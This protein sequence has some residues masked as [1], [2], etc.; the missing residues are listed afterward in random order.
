MALGFRGLSHPGCWF[1]SGQDCFLSKTER[2]LGLHTPR[3]P[4]C[5]R[6]PSDVG[7]YPR[8]LTSPS[9]ASTP[10]KFPGPGSRSCGLVVVTSPL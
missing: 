9:A 6:T 10:E 4:L 2:H 5:A 7:W 3:R 1:L 8:V